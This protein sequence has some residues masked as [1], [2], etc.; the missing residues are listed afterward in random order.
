MSDQPDQNDQKDMTRLR[1]AAAENEDTITAPA[2]RPAPRWLSKLPRPENPNHV[3]IMLTAVVAVFGTVIAFLQVD[4]NARSAET[5]RDG[6]KQAILALQSQ[7]NGTLGYGYE[8]RTYRAWLELT[9][10]AGLDSRLEQKAPD[11]AQVNALHQEAQRMLTAAQSLA[12]HSQLLPDDPNARQRGQ[13]DPYQYQLDTVIA[14]NLLASEEREAYG[15]VSGAWGAKGNAYRAII[16]LTAATLFLYGLAL[17]VEGWLKWGFVGLGTLNVGAISLWALITLLQPVPRVSHDAIRAYVTGFT[18]TAYA[19][20]LEYWSIYDRVPARAQKAI[21]SLD[22]AIALRQDYA[23]AYQTRADA[24]LLTGESLSF[25][26]GDPALS[27]A[28]LQHAVSDFWQA[29]RLKPDDYHTLWNL[30]YALYLLGDYQQ[31]IEIL[32]Q[33]LA[34]APQQQLG[35]GMV[36]AGNQLGLGHVK[37]ALAECQRAIDYAAEHPTSADVIYFR[38]IIRNLKRWRAIRPQPGMAEM[39]LLVKEA[40]VSLQYRNT[41][42]VGTTNG[43]LNN[44][45]FVMLTFDQKGQPARYQQGTNFSAGTEQVGVLFD[46][47]DMKDGEQVVMKVY[48]NGQENAFFNQVVSWADG[49]SGHSDRLAVEW[50]VKRSMINLP[51]GQYEVEI[52]VEGNLRA[53][54]AFSI[55]QPAAGQ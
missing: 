10:L 37:E 45:A 40:F 21:A 24:Y 36:L 8:A 25:S 5:G 55:E 51:S 12:D 7:V 35:L 31:S 48:Y 26:G 50:P 39:E 3:I 46:Y 27:A 15:E 32:N 6:Q 4:A 43:K 52:Y 9:N 54:G 23:S 30:G 1:L 22:Q 18:N 29:L 28:A 49:P 13:I 44:L 34:L 2:A 17:V 11:P 42:H 38:Q 20:G 19:L 47:S 53:Q 33:A 14:P 16:T 41:Q